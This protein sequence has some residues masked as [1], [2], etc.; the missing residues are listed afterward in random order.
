VTFFVFR[1]VSLASIIAALALPVAAWGAG[2]PPLVIG[3][4][5]AVALFVVLRHRTNITRLLAG[6]ESKFQR[7][8]SSPRSS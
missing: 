2:R 7:P 5:A 4:A 8:S 1:Y 6:T 3:I